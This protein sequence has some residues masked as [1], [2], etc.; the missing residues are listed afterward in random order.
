[1]KENSPDNGCSDLSGSLR[2]LYWNEQNY[3]CKPME[4]ST[5]C[6]CKIF[7]LEGTELDGITK[8]HIATPNHDQSLSIL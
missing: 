8:V 3:K 2:F 4:V 1:M 7:A 5:H 6:S